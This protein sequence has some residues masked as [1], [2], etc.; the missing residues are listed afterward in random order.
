MAW[1]K[2]ALGCAVVFSQEWNDEMD[3]TRVCSGINA[4]RCSAENDLYH[5]FLSIAAFELSATAY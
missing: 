3:E 1:P 2:G 4:R 5:G